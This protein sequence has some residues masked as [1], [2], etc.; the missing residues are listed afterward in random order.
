MLDLHPRVGRCDAVVAIATHPVLFGH[1]R[2]THGGSASAGRQQS[3]GLGL[4]FCKL[5]AEAHGGRIEVES[6]LGAGTTFRVL[7]P[8]G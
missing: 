7:L 8:A 6:T 4:S 5:A 3:T 2:F 1:E